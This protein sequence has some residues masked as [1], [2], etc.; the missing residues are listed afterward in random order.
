[1]A[2]DDTAFDTS[3]KS[4]L[5]CALRGATVFAVRMEKSAGLGLESSQWSLSMESA[6][7]LCISRVHVDGK[8]S[9][10][11]STVWII[12]PILVP[13]MDT[14]AIERDALEWTN[15]RLGV[16]HAA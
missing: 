8:F 16:T 6:S 11:R 4:F 14:I 12:L 5:E 13:V 7:L 9:F 1:M 15:V 10:W 2:N 3:M